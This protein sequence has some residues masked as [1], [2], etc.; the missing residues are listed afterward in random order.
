MITDEETKNYSVRYEMPIGARGTRLGIAYSETNY[1][2]NSYN[3]GIINL[4]TSEN[5]KAS[6]STASRR[7]TEANPT[8]S[9][10]STATTAA[11]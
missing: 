5:P 8:A 10:S 3:S 1:D 11:T 9:H 2:F 4:T 7:S 6:A